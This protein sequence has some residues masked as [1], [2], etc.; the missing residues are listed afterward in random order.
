MLWQ[1][2]KKKD[3]GYTTNGTYNYWGYNAYNGTNNQH[4]FN[5][6]EDAVQAICDWFITRKDSSGK[7]YNS[8]ISTAEKYAKENSNFTGE[9]ENNLYVIF[10]T[11][12]YLGNTHNCDD[13]G[14]GKSYAER[15]A[16]FSANGGASNGGRYYTFEMYE[17]GWIAT[18]MYDEMCGSV[19]PNASDAT[20]MKE[21]ADYAQYSV[22]CRVKIAEDIFGVGCVG[23]GSTAT[24]ENEIARKVID[25]ALSKVGCEY[26]QEAG[27]RTGPNSFD[28]SGLMYYAFQQVGI[29]IPETTS[30]YSNYNQYKLSN[31]KNAAPGDILWRS[32]HVAMYLGNGNIVE[33]KG[34][35][36][37]VCVSEYASLEECMSKRGFVAVYRFWN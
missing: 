15:L 37:G 14:Q 28:C 11:Y 3:N 22:D 5:T 10:C 13:A 8:C 7:N 2:Q 25:I 21:R 24:A 33:A 19:H 35:D 26:T 4:N 27:R 9:P 20:T 6:M 36:Y 12:A 34:K 18:G 30:Y 17:N 29:T 31:N 1:W 32:G 16:I 23:K